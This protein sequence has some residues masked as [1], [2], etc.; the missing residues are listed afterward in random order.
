M[1]GYLRLC[2]AAVGDLDRL[3]MHTISRLDFD[4]RVNSFSERL[5]HMFMVR[6]LDPLKN[7]VD[8]IVKVTL[9]VSENTMGHSGARDRVLWKPR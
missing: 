2:P 7:P 6:S 4:L 8:V 1:H 3:A 9:V 5:S